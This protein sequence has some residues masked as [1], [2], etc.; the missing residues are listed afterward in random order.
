MHGEEEREWRRRLA[1]AHQVVKVSWCA[2]TA[3]T[4][5]NTTPTTMGMTRR[6]RSPMRSNQR[7][8]RSANTCISTCKIHNPYYWIDFTNKLFIPPLSAQQDSRGPPPG[9][10]VPRAGHLVQALVSQGREDGP[11]RPSRSSRRRG[12]AYSLSTMPTPWA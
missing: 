2:N 7:M 8:K 6:A 11:P 5:I 4:T 9:Q 12:G 3:T 1:E 10:G